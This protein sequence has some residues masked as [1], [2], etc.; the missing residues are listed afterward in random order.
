MITGNGTSLKVTVD[1]LYL[2][3]GVVDITGL[4]TDNLIDNISIRKNGSTQVS[5]AT[6]VH[7]TTTTLGGKVP[8][9]TTSLLDLNTDDILDLFVERVVGAGTVQIALFQEPYY[10]NL[11]AVWMGGPI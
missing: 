8:L 5:T 10:T 2:V 7:S 1:G 4:N 6:F 9:T 3:G 11:W